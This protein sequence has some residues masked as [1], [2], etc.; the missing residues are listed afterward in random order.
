VHQGLYSDPASRLQ[1]SIEV[2]LHQSPKP[3]LTRNFE[4]PCA[5]GEYHMKIAFLGLRAG[6]GKNNPTELDCFPSPY[7]VS[8]AQAYKE[9]TTPEHVFLAA[10]LPFQVIVEIWKHAVLHE[11]QLSQATTAAYEPNLVGQDPEV[12]NALWGNSDSIQGIAHGRKALLR[13]WGFIGLAFL[14]TLVGDVMVVLH[15]AKV[16]YL[17]RPSW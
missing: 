5:A 17:L 14:A 1:V 11:D 7:G 2:T 6:N 9:E 8:Y 3:H 13:T 12:D 4:T 15:C 16:P 10:S